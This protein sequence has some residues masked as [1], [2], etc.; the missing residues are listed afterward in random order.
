MHRVRNGIALAAVVAI[1]I[2][3]SGAGAGRTAGGTAP[4]AAGW[5]GL[6]GFRPVPQLGDREIVVLKLAS[7]SDRVRAAGGAATEAQEKAWTREA[8]HA[9]RRVLVRLSALGVPVQ[10]EQSYV[11]V[12][13]GFSAALDA[14]TVAALEKDADVDAVYPVRAAY[15]AA[16][17]TDVAAVA[18]DAAGATPGVALPGFDGRGVVVA[19]LD[20]GI[21]VA[22]LYLQDRLLPGIDVLD[23]T[24]GAVAQQ[25]PLEPG[26]FEAHATQ[27]AGLV[28]GSNGPDGLHGV[29]PGASILPIRVAGWQPDI[30]GGVAVYGRTDQL[31][32]GIEA[33]VDPDANGDAHD[34]ARIALVGVVEPDAGFADGPLAL[35]AAGAQALDTMLVVPVG[36]DGPAGP[37]FGDVGGPGGAP[38][39]LAVA[40]E[41]QRPR[42]PTAHVLLRTGLRVLLHGEQPLGGPTTLPQPID[43]RVVVAD[44]RRYFDARGYNTVAGHAVLLPRGVVTHEAVDQ[45]ATA[46][47]AAVL[48]DGS[49]PAGALGSEAPGQVPVLGVPQAAADA[50][51]ADLAAGRPVELSVGATSIGA[52]PGFDAEAPFSSSGLAFDGTPKPDLVAPG[53]GLVTSEPGKTA[54]GDANFAAASGSSVAAAV[55][56]GAAALLAQARPGLDAAA[57][58]SALAQTTERA[59]GGDRGR[60]GS[61]DVSAAAETEVVVSPPAVAFGVPL[62]VGNQVN[63]DI[64]VRNVSRRR[65][66]I[67]LDPAGTGSGARLEMLPDKLVLLPG[68][69]ASVGVFGRVPSLPAAPG[70]LTGAFRVVPRFGTPFRVR[71]AIAVPVQG[72]PLL[73]QVRL[74]QT[75]FAPSDA[76]PSVLSLVAGRVDGSPESPQL[77]PLSELRIDLF[78]GN[79]L[80]GT[81]AR[82][83][84]LLPGRYAFGLTGRGPRGRQLPRGEYSVRLVATPVAGVPDEQTVRFRVIRG[85]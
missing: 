28:A 23:P 29:A 82:V 41:D 55:V 8:E 59:L 32:A 84:D 5:Q 43:A 50:V 60:T 30:T 16:T 69:S 6:L 71:W 80:L 10:P 27:L 51:R 40:A 65:L 83:R 58:Q 19:L 34:A 46:G 7:L 78:H 53:V 39:A 37:S 13:N 35:A 54:A 49:I 45:A 44:P 81:I 74:S 48:V 85:G 36:N 56:A 12:F 73:A 64:T 61:V 4:S 77:M 66:T 1:V 15:P 20:T 79:H 33:A 72:K 9:Q 24:S 57:L 11:R 38:A 67:T 25:N 76:N 17:S 26:S 75:T 31:L 21:D 14:G 22:H 63:A 70:G 3:L 68:G 2:A 52:N 62:G 18:A 42:A 47:V